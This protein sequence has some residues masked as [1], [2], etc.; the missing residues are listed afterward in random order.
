MANAG[1]LCAGV[2]KHAFPMPMRDGKMT[3]H[4]ENIAIR[5]QAMDAVRVRI[6]EAANTRDYRE[7]RA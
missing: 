5:F 3:R 6:L 7:S 4:E 1:R 2:A